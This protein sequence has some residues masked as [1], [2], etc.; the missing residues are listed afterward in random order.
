MVTD[1]TG[2]KGPIENDLV[3]TPD[4]KS[5]ITIPG[6]MKINM[7][8]KSKNAAANYNSG[9]SLIEDEGMISHEAVTIMPSS[10][11]GT[12]SVTQSRA[13]SRLEI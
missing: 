8:S 3:V 6:S 7:N 10:S 1:E 12:H 9:C 2:W 4:A 13:V 11:L 5:M